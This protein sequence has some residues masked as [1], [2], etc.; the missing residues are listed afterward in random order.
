[1]RTII[2]G[3]TGLIGR[4]LAQLL[5]KAGHEVSILSRDPA[6]YSFPEGVQGVQ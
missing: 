3:G 2:T 1:M 6:R 5:V 4:E